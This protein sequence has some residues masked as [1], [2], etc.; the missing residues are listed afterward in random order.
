MD[1]LQV[2]RGRL[3]HLHA[4]AHRAG[5]RNH[6]RGRVIDHGSPVVRSPVM[7]LSTPRQ[8]HGA[9]LGEQKGRGGRG[10]AR[11]QHLVLPAAIAARSSRPPFEWVVPRRHLTD[12]ADRLAADQD[13]WSF[14]ISPPTCRRGCQRAGEEPDLVDGHGISSFTRLARGLPVSFDSTSANS[15]A[16]ASIASAMR[17]SAS[18]RSPGVVSPKLSKAFGGR[19]EGRVDILFRRDRRRRVAGLGGRIEE[20]EA[21]VRRRLHIFA[22][23]EVSNCALAH[24]N[25]CSEIDRCALGSPLR[26]S[27]VKTKQ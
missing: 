2:G 17:N 13:V 27:A 9:D 10:V 3:R 11:L 20:L 7:T 1:A 24:S 26:I 19:L 12:D 25:D 18:W 4:R 21:R 15:S 22:V 8:E 16:R 14:C 5:D 23:D 6:L